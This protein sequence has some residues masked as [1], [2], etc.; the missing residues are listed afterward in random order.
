M[1][2]F[3]TIK[4]A[5]LFEI[6]VPAVAKLSKEDNQLVISPTKPLTVRVVEFVPVQTVV[7]P[8]TLP[9]TD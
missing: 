9:P 6:V 3:V 5:V 1:V 4:L 7:P 2:K 8:E